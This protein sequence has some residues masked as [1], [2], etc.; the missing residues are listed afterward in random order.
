MNQV[1]ANSAKVEEPTAQQQSQ[2][3]TVTYVEPVAQTPESAATR[4][5]TAV[6]SETTTE[7]AATSTDQPTADESTVTQSKIT[8]QFLP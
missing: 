2:I 1:E 3:R 8:A 4:T 5:P 6:A 7:A